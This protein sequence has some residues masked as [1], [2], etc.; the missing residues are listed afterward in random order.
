MAA[1]AKQNRDLRGEAVLRTARPKER[2]DLVKWLSAQ[3]AERWQAAIEVYAAAMALAAL[4]A[5]Y[6][7]WSAL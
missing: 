5:L 4:V 1:A 6:F 3:D 7:P 2:S